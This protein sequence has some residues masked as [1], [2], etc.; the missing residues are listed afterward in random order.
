MKSQAVIL[1]LT[2]AV[3]AHECCGQTPVMR[4]EISPLSSN[5]SLGRSRVESRSCFPSVVCT[6]FEY[7]CVSLTFQ[8]WPFVENQSAVPGSDAFV[9]SE[10]DSATNRESIT[11]ILRPLSGAFSGRQEP[12]GWVEL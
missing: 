5:I 2:A 6:T 3:G 1:Q 4:C 10:T 12:Q 11:I 7:G 9:V 8:V